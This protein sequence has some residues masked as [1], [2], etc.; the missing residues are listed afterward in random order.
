MSK[1]TERKD[2]GAFTIQSPQES[3][4]L[5]QLV[6]R[7]QKNP[8]KPGQAWGRVQASR[9]R[10]GRTEQGFKVYHVDLNANRL[11][12]TEEWDKVESARK[13]VPLDAPGEEREVALGPPPPDPG[14]TDPSFYRSP[15]H[16]ADL[17]PE[18]ELREWAMERADED[19][20]GIS[21]LPRR[22]RLFGGRF[23]EV[24]ALPQP[25]APS[26]APGT[27]ATL[28]ALW[29]RPGVERRLVEGWFGSVDARGTAWILEPAD[30]G[31]WWLAMRTFERR[32]GMI[33]MW[34]SAWSQRTGRGLHEL[35]ASLRGVME[36]PPG[37]RAIEVGSPKEPEPPEIGMFGGTLQPQEEVPATAE[38]V[39]D[40]IGREWEAKLP[41]G[42]T[43]EGVRVTV[44]RGREWETWV[45]DGVLPMGLDDMVRAIAARGETPTSLAVVRM[46]VIP[47]EGDVY[48]ALLTDGEA[49]GRRWTRAFLIRMAP[50]G[51]ITGHRIAVR[52][53][54]EV[55]DDGWIGVP[56]VTDMSLFV[57]GAGE[58]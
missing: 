57:L 28:R 27:G 44:F 20:L 56:P 31:S 25:L 54:G 29:S 45:L 22:I 42:E 7:A 48:R 26:V 51:T 36:S 18:E 35:S 39:A 2:H 19:V 32:P 46:G 3:V 47:M 34:T 1:K 38:A 5:V 8:E 15:F 11:T 43:P 6:E 33:G 40:R 49:Q 13:T 17:L 37:E 10:N 9:T 4:M 21:A 23:H 41:L 52:K 16:A 24:V 55:G 50:D 58:A 12:I 53:H 14:P 30:D